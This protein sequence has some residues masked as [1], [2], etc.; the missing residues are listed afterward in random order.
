MEVLGGGDWG[1]VKKNGGILVNEV[2]FVI[3]NNN[4]QF[5]IEEGR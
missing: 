4:K 5:V 2:N 3:I 1:S